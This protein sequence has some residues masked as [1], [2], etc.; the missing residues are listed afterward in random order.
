VRAA[1][2]R[3]AAPAALATGKIVQPLTAPECAPMAWDEAAGACGAPGGPAVGVKEVSAR[4]R[5]H[6]GGLGPAAAAHPRRRQPCGAFS[7][8]HTPNHRARPWTRPASRAATR[9]RRGRSCGRTARPRRPAGRAPPPRRGCCR[10]SAPP[11]PA[12]PAQ[13]TAA[14]LMGAAAAAAGRAPTRPPAPCCCA[15]TRECRCREP[16]A[17]VPLQPPGRGPALA[18]PCCRSAFPSRHNLGYPSRTPTP[19]A[20]LRRTWQL[21]AA[22]RRTLPARSGPA[23]SSQRGRRAPSATARP[24]R[25]RSSVRAW[26]C[27]SSTRC[28]C[29]ASC[30]R[31]RVAGAARWGRHSWGLAVG[32]RRAGAPAAGPQTA[33]LPASPFTPS[34]LVRLEP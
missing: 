11:A 20:R 24:A 32:S 8:S 22:R 9:P 5:P 19:A 29:G 4:S 12:L 2:P 13:M 7:H 31:G 14:H 33:R 16:C 28:W 1:R 3:A 10:S 6:R 34:T 15:L 25:P 30:R 27:C 23:S 26:R 18:C 21:H 17:R